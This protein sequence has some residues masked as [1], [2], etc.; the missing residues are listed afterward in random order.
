MTKT[1]S[2]QVSIKAL[3][4][5]YPRAA[6]ARQAYRETFRRPAGFPAMAQKPN[7]E[8]LVPGSHPDPASPN[9]APIKTAQD[10]RSGIILGP[11]RWVLSISLAGVIVALL[12]VWFAVR[13]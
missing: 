1:G 8:K 9:H 7:P 13:R 4:L 12:I 2:G 5:N 10:A 3:G 11:M 6:M